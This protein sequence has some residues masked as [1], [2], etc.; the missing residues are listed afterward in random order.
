[1]LPDPE[2]MG[3]AVIMSLLP[4]VQAEIYVFEVLR[5]LSWFFHLR[6]PPVCSYNNAPK[7][8]RLLDSK[9]I[10]KAVAISLLSCVQAEMNVFE[11]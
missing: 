6:F 5:P 2:N 8:I 10:G 3:K 1:M 7:F 4:R 11:V 9:N